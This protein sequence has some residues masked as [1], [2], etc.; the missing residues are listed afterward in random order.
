LDQELKAYLEEREAR[1]EARMDERFGGIDER[2]ARVE[3]D[4][5]HT[6]ILVEGLDG[7]VR[8]LA[9]AVVGT[10]ERMDALRAG[11]TGSLEVIKGTIKVIHETLLPRVS[12]LEERV[13]ILEA[14]EERE[15]RDI[16][17]VV[18]ERFGLRQT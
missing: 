17:E 9:E 18:R 14:R 5:R 11:T 10:G 2:F 15:K 1:M 16:L 6:R 12:S 3:T 13:T 4:V 7:K 8:L